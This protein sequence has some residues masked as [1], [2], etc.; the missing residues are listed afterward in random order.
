[1]HNS[2]GACCHCRDAWP[3][4]RCGPPML[5]GIV[6]QRCSRAAVPLLTHLALYCGTQLGVFFL[7]YPFLSSV[8]LQRVDVLAEWTCVPSGGQNDNTKQKSTRT[9]EGFIPAC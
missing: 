1:M 8:R 9:S 2:G 4:A 5:S 7:S 3:S 6:P